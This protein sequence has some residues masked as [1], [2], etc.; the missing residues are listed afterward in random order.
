MT[1]PVKTSQLVQMNDKSSWEAVS[2]FQAWMADHPGVTWSSAV[3]VQNHGLHLTS[4]DATTTLRFT[5]LNCGYN[6]NGP[7]S[8]VQL[9]ELAG[10]GT[11]T[12]LEPIIFSR[13]KVVL[14]T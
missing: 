11:K 2:L 13:S 4:S 5:T 7:I 6:G 9:L 14:S 8:T 10:F 1:S 12:N 3:V